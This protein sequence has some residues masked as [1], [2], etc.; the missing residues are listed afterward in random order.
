[1]ACMDYNVEL[2]KG[3]KEKRWVCIDGRGEAGK[4]FRKGGKE[5]WGVD[6]KKKGT[7]EG[8]DVFCYSCL[9]FRNLPPF[10]LLD[11]PITASSPSNFPFIMFHLC[12][13]FLLLCAI[14]FLLM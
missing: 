13:P 4:V 10:C 7:S 12:C 9:R 3:M 5:N 6:M 11:Q 1:M 14:P 2:A 8:H